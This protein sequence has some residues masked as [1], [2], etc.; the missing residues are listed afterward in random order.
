VHTIP[1]VNQPPLTGGH[2]TDKGAPDPAG[3]A[4]QIAMEHKLPLAVV[5][6]VLGAPRSSVYARRAAAGAGGRPGPATSISDADLLGL[7]HQV[8]ATSPFAG[9]GYRKIRARLRRE[10]GVQV[11]GKRVLRLLRAHGLLA[12]QRV[13]GRRKPRP[14]TARSSPRRPTSAGARMRPWPGPRP[15]GGCGCSPAST[16]TPPRPGRTWPRWATGSPPWSRSMTRSSTAGPA[17]RRCRP[18]PGTAARL[19]TPIPLSPFHRLAGLAGHHRQPGV[20]G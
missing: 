10:H 8:L 13:R 4:A 16:T 15:T 12:P 3:E 5:C 20:P 14:M 6:R 19:G 7:I 11:S 17:G 9:E 1:S 18:R 2:C